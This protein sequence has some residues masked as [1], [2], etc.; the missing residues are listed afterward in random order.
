MKYQILWHDCEDNRTGT[1]FEVQGSNINEAYFK[2]EN[3]IKNLS[4]YLREHYCGVD[5]EFLIDEQGKLHD[6]EI[7]LEER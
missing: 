2:A 3:H 5:I 7:F 4:P 1:P 6:P